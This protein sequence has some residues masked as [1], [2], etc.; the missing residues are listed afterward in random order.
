MEMGH[1][2]RGSDETSQQ[3]VRAVRAALCVCVSVCLG[4]TVV[5][6]LV[7]HLGVAQQQRH[8]RRGRGGLG[9][10]MRGGEVRESGAGAG[11]R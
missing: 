2:R 7:V 6:V 9:S 8:Y 1:R 10:L 5:L 11:E 3:L 4:R